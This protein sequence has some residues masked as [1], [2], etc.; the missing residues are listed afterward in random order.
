MTRSKMPSTKLWFH[1]EDYANVHLCKRW[2]YRHWDTQ[3]IMEFIPNSRGGRKLCF[4]SYMYNKK[5]TETTVIQWECMSRAPIAPFCVSLLHRRRGDCASEDVL[6][7]SQYRHGTCLMPL[8]TTTL[9]QITC[10]DRG[11]AGWPWPSISLATD[12]RDAEGRCY[13]HDGHWAW[14]PWRFKKATRAL[15]LHRQR[16]C[17]ARCNNQKTV[18]QTL[19]AAGHTIRFAWQTRELCMIERTVAYRHIAYVIEMFCKYMTFN[20]SVFQL[21]LIPIISLNFP[22]TGKY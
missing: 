16:I 18:V 7:Y 4:A 20:T 17:V 5:S 2:L 6:P 15:Q 21:Q 13:G 1:T 22:S 9:A 12:R 19:S 11:T 3:Y 10:A 8:W 14:L